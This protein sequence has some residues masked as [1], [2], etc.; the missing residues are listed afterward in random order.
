MNEHNQTLPFDAITLNQR[1]YTLSQKASGTKEDKAYPLSYLGAIVISGKDR[2]TFL[3]GQLTIDVVKTNGAA[4][5]LY[6]DKDGRI[7]SLYTFIKTDENIYL[8]MPKDI[9]ENTLKT[10]KKY[11]M[12]SK[13][14]FD[15]PAVDMW[16]FTGEQVKEKLSNILTDDK[17]CISQMNSDTVFVIHLERTTESTLKAIK[18][19]FDILGSLAW[20]Q[21]EL[22]NNIP[23]IYANSQN[24]FLP[25][26]LGLHTKEMINFNKG[27]FLGQEIIARMHYKAKLKHEVM[28]IKSKHSHLPTEKITINEKDIGEVI[29]ISI[30]EGE[31]YTLLCAILTKEAHALKEHADYRIV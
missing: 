3:Q 24:H 14:S 28:L 27:C 20:H 11:G 21:L 17:N 26:R 9:I 15:T 16:A 6:C 5:G 1:D 22:E 18:E 12:F 10:L 29:D 19:R 31:D 13:V 2:E 8:V 23:S 7:I 30:N 25:H 4:Y